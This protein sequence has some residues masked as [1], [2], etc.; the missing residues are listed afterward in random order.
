M[1]SFLPQ[2]WLGFMP[3]GDKEGLTILGSSDVIVAPAVIAIPDH[4]GTNGQAGNGLP[5]IFPTSYANSCEINMLI[6]C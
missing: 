6:F 2:Y 3:V 5:T 1:G 4:P